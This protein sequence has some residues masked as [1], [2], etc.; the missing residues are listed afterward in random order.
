MHQ[1]FVGMK[2]LAEIFSCISG[3][4]IT[5]WNFSFAKGRAWHLAN[6]RAEPQFEGVMPYCHGIHQCDKGGRRVTQECFQRKALSWDYYIK[7]NAY[8]DKHFDFF[9]FFPWY[10]DRSPDKT[11]CTLTELCITITRLNMLLGGASPSMVHTSKRKSMM[12][13]R[14]R[15]LGKTYL[16]IV[17]K[18]FWLSCSSTLF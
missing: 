16:S 17:L 2:E 4:H 18:G 11:H 12:H 13:W 14:N 7:Q 1:C 8:S 15:V 10:P 6:Q 5:K 9:S 3:G